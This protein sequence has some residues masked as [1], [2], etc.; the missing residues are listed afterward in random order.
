M[1]LLYTINKSYNYNNI[2][3][4]ENSLF[5]FNDIPDDIDNIENEYK[6][7]YEENNYTFKI[8]V[9]KDKKIIKLSYIGSNNNFEDTNTLFFKYKIIIKYEKYIIKK[10]ENENLYEIFSDK[11]EC[12]TF[13]EY[14][15]ENILEGE[16]KN[17][18]IIDIKLIIYGNSKIMI[19]ND[20]TYELETEI[21]EEYVN[22]DYHEIINKFNKRQ[23]SDIQI[24]L[25]NNTSNII[26]V[27][28]LI[29]SSQSEYFNNLFSTNMVD[30]NKNII[31]FKYIDYNIGFN[32]LK[33]MYTQNI[34]DIIYEKNNENII[35]K[36]LEFYKISDMWLMKKL[37]NDIINI[38]IKNISISNIYDLLTFSNNYNLNNLK[39]I[40]FNFVKNNQSMIDNEDYL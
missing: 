7:E 39:K 27:S 3:D 10:Y 17:N 11:S 6:K 19:H 26:F 4:I 2:F 32:I 8:S 33:Y 31:E 35:H 18:I 22:Y 16:E 13:L 29:L 28:K 14:N 15:F 25:N 38:L 40:L 5:S 21:E 24:I 20:G 23:Y 37:S 9:D 12:N 34:N 30:S 1:K 36:L